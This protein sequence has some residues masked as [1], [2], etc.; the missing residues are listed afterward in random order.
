MN[1]AINGSMVYSHLTKDLGHVLSASNDT[2]RSTV[3]W[4]CTSIAP[5]DLH[6][7]FRFHAMYKYIYLDFFSFSLQFGAVEFFSLTPCMYLCFILLHLYVLVR[8]CLLLLPPS[9][10]GI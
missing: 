4:H 5:Y 7:T 1:V 10:R 3:H 6:V 8:D 2:S 9:L